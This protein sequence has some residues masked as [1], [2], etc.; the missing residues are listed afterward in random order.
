M[1]K[2]YD[3]KYIEIKCSSCSKIIFREGKA[4]RYYCKKF[5]D[6]YKPICSKSCGKTKKVKCDECGE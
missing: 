5:G 2:K 1:D 6:N 3:K 4:H